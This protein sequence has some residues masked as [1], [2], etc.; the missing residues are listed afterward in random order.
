MDYNEC[1]TYLLAKLPMFS[2]IGPAAMK[3]GLSN[4]LKMCAAL[5]NPQERFKTIHVAGTNGKGSVSHMLASILQ[6]AGYKTGLYTSPHLVDFRERIRIN[7]KMISKEKVIGFTQQMKPMIDTADLSF[8]ELTVGMAFQYFA[9]EKVD[10]AVIETGL[11]G[12][13][14]STNVIQPLLS[15]IT[16]I[17]L[18]HTELL[19]DT[20]EKIAAEK[21]GIIKHAVPVLI[22][23]IQP[24]SKP[25]FLKKAKQENAPITFA[26]DHYKVAVLKTAPNGLKI[27]L[28]SQINGHTRIINVA[29][30]GLYQTENTRTVVA[31]IDLLR[32]LG[33]LVSDQH[34]AEGIEN[35]VVNTG[36]HGRWEPIRSS[37]LLILDVAHNTDGITTLLDQLQQTNY[38][39]LFIVLGMSKEKDV[40]SILTLLPKDALYG[41][42]QANIPRAMEATKLAEMATEM[43]LRGSVYQ[44]V[45]LA[46]AGILEQA[47]TE[48]LVLVCGSI[49]VV[50]EVD[51]KRFAQ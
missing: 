40:Q 32:S 10:I 46:I 13:L 44:D 43:S 48:D 9:E 50:G 35:M 8:F 38:K 2:R 21:A 1:L 18:D 11:G 19:G 30:T 6:T 31:A 17:G 45:N 47:T 4:T 25:V 3:P 14:D 16:N 23:K 33:W 29:L 27:A 5:D 49:F 37:P 42:T 28:N 26:E 51:R 20:I 22:G 34:T 12:R 24:E 41:F 39:N 15:I 36:L 7:G